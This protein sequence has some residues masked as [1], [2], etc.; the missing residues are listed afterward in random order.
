MKIAICDDEKLFLDKL[1]NLLKTY[2][3]NNS[4]LEIFEFNTGESFLKTFQAQKYDIVILDIEMEDKTKGLY[5]AEQIRK[6]DN[7]VI[8]VFITS[9]SEFATE[10]YEINA[11]RYILKQQPENIYQRQ[12]NSIFNEYQQT[13]KTLSIKTK[14]SLHMILINDIVYFEVFKKIIVV[15]TLKEKFEFQGTLKDIMNNPDLLTFIQTH[16]SY[17]VNME[18]I[19]DIKKTDIFLSTNDKIPLS[20]SLKQTVID[21]F[22]NFVTVRY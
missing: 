22:L 11:F 6:V 9:H 4:N 14:D 2:C 20:R 13:H 10:G 17:Y 3:P 1:K 16:K 18:Y 19:K 15:H 5:V 12:F 7:S 8:I 21:K